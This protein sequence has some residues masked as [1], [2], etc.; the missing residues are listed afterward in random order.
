MIEINIEGENFKEILRKDLIY[1]NI[2]ITK[3]RASTSFSY[4]LKNH[5]EVNLTP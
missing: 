5:I 4:F 3:T 1:D 2:K